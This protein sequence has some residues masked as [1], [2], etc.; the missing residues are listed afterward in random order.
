MIGSGATAPTFAWGGTS[1]DQPSVTTSALR[2]VSTN[3]FRERVSRLS[4]WVSGPA[5]S[6][7]YAVSGTD[8]SSEAPGLMASPAG[9]GYS[10]LGYTA[11]FVGNEEKPHVTPRLA[12]SG[13]GIGTDDSTTYAAVGGTS[14][15]GGVVDARERRLFLP[16]FVKR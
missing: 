11:A 15:L 4:A 6:G 16:R 3:P 14:S 1:A 7:S 8:I 2:S 10:T 13:S 5:V 9:G 12:V